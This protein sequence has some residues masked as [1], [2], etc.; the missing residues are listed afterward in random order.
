M[1]ANTADS[2]VIGMIANKVDTIMKKVGS[3]TN[4]PITCCVRNQA[5]FI[6][7]TIGV[8]DSSTVLET[9]TPITFTNLQNNIAFAEGDTLSIEYA[10]GTATDFIQVRTS[11]GFFNS[12][13]AGNTV[14]FESLQTAINTSLPVFRR[15]LAATIYSGGKPDLDAR[16]IRGVMVNSVNSVL[17]NRAITEV[18]LKLRGSGIL[19]LG[20][21]LK[22]K[23]IRGSDKTTQAILGE[24]DI[25]SI[26]TDFAV[27]Y[28]FQNT[29][30]TY[31]MKVGD[32][33]G[34]EFN[35]GDPSHYVEARTSVSDFYDGQNTVMFEYNGTAYTAVTDRDLSGTMSI[36]GFTVTPDPIS[37]PPTPPFH[38]AHEWI[39]GA[40]GPPDSDAVRDPATI[41]PK[42]YS[43][44][45]NIA[46]QFRIYD[47]LLTPNQLQNYYDNRFTITPIPKGRVEIVGHDIV[48]IDAISTPV[49]G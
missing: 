26:S 5:G 18:R 17:Y 4:G 9:N 29:D 12:S 31:V 2:V 24:L 46:K 37:V 33:I 49:T 1:K 23:V 15:D 21:T 25:N 6:K 44:Y 36:G 43:F 45:N 32:M 42:T 39:I 30:N 40:S 16:P 14:L 10:N 27:E 20:N 38:Y 48:P 19:P 7:A 22:V 41:F 35:H 8:V 3:P 11:N 13:D 28:Y 47:F 34:L